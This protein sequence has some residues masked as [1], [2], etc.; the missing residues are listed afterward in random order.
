[1][2]VLFVC[3]GNKN[4]RPGTVVKNQA[5]S[6]SRRGIEIE[7]FL[8][9]GRGILGYLRH[10]PLLY[11][12]IKKNHY[13]LV[14]AH[15]SDSACIATIAGAKPLVVS[16]MGTDALGGGI[17]GLIIKLFSPRW[18]SII[19][20]SEEIK[21]ASRLHKA[22]VIPNGVNLSSF[23]WLDRN[24]ARKT[25]GW[26][27]TKKYVLF[28]AD[29]ARPE[30]NYALAQKA[31]NIIKDDLT[32]LKIVFNIPHAETRIYFYASDVVLLT[33]L[34]EG[35]P[36]VVKE[37]LACNIPVVSTDVGDV[38]S[39]T[40]GVQGCFVTGSNPEAIADA[41][42]TALKGRRSSNGRQR[43][44]DRKLDERSIAEKVIDIYNRQI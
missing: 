14:H 1:M 15:Y 41:L 27:A 18:N 19:V 44:I 37:A 8:I 25:L 20:K 33:S 39:L 13:Q 6:L 17:S 34:H 29:P 31:F 36:N 26:G 42:L 22:I 43:I 38:K 7:F 16:L 9:T 2:R 10:I 28:L 4:G 23:E 32:E 5:D 12:H 11:S 21:K 40:S 3:S 24:E 30:K 35:S